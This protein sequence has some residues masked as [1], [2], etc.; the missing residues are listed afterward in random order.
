MKIRSCC[1]GSGK[2]IT[3]IRWKKHRLSHTHTHREKDRQTP[4]DIGARMLCVHTRISW[5][6]Y[7]C[8]N[9]TF[10][11]GTSVCAPNFSLNFISS[12]REEKEYRHQHNHHQHSEIASERQQPNGPKGEKHKKDEPY[13]AK[14]QSM[15]TAMITA[16]L[17]VKIG[18]PKN[19]VQ[20]LSSAL[21]EPRDERKIC[22]MNIHA[23]RTHFVCTKH[24]AL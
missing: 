10:L 16:N 14:W 15:V 2:K 20:P 24:S 17:N 6:I 3:I 11:E 21:R 13:P 9:T 23:H 12:H 4:K 7:L 19:Q 22:T 18:R 8:K 5:T 1:G